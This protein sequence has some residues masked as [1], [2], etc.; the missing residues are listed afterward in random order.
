MQGGLCRVHIFSRQSLQRP[1]RSGEIQKR[2][3]PTEIHQT[4]RR[5]QLSLH[6]KDHQRRR[7]LP[8]PRCL[9]SFVPTERVIIMIYSTLLLFYLLILWI[10]D[11]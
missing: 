10:W 8:A 5:G 7:D 2:Q 6:R 1:I 4:R 3:T 11:K 9:R